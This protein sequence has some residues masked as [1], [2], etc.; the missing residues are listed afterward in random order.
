MQ[1]PSNLKIYQQ[2]AT[3]L[4]D[5]GFIKEI[6]FAGS[7]YQVLVEDPTLHKSCWV[8]LQLEGKGHIRDAFCS[9]E[10][11]NEWENSSPCVHLAAAYLSL[12]GKHSMPLHQRFARSLWNNLCRIY[13]DRLGDNPGRL[14]SIQPGYY[15]IQTGS[16][17][18]IFSVKAKSGATV[19]D[20]EN[21]VHRRPDET[22]ETSIKFSNLPEEEL[23]LWK[24]GKPSS[25]LR[26]ELSYWSDVAKWLMRLQ[27][28]EKKY[29]I[30]FKFSKKQLPN[31]IQIDFDEIE[32]GFYLSD[33]NL[34]A[35][36]PSLATVNSPLGVYQANNQGIAA[37]TYDKK[38]SSLNIESEIL[39]GTSLKSKRKKENTQAVFIEGWTYIPEQGFYSDEP[40]HLSQTPVLKGE[41]LANALTEYSQLI[42]RFLVDYEIHLNPIQVLHK[43]WFDR[44][45]NLHIQAYLLEEGDLSRNNSRIIGDWAF[46]DEDGF[47]RLEGKRFDEVDT[48]IPIQQVAD[49]VTLNRSW[50]NAQEGFET[51]VRSV[52]YQLSYSVNQN[53]RLSFSRTV[54]KMKE[55][56]KIQDFGSWVYLEGFGF[57]P[58]SVSSFG[59]LVRP[60]ISLSPE[61]IP[62]FI[63]MNHD[64]L[65]LIPE[66]F[67]PT[68]PVIK[69]S[70]KVELTDRQSVKITPEYELQPKYKNRDVRFFDEVVYV[71]GEGFSQLPP[72]LHLDE[73]YRHTVEL[74]GEDRDLFL[75]YEIFEFQK[76]ITSLD[77]RLIQPQEKL[78]VTNFV[79]TAKE[80]GRGW[81]QFAFFYKTEKGLISIQTMLTA[82][83]KKQTLL[84][85]DEGLIDL[86]DKR[87]DWL[88]QL[89]KNRVSADGKT[90]YLNALEF[91]RLNA[92]DPIDFLKTK[93]NSSESSQE[94]FDELLQLKTPEEPDIS[95]LLSHLRPYQ[96]IGVHWLWFLYHQQLSGLL[97]DD[98]GLGKTHQAMALLASI[99]NLYKTY[100]EG[101]SRHFLIVCPTSVIFHWQDKLQEFLPGIRIH[102]F[103][104]SNRSLDEFQEQYDVLLT[105]YGILRNE[106]EVL[107]KIPFEVAI[108]DEI[109]IAKNQSSRIY[110][111]LT[112][113]NSQMKLG[114]T[115]TPIENY[116]RE[117]KSLFDIVLPS[118]MPGE[119]DYRELFVRP[120]EREQNSHRKGLL[121]RLIKP[122][123]LRR[124]KEDVLKDLPEK[125]EEISHCELLPYQRQLY[126]EVLLQRRRHLLQE[127]ENESNPIPFL[128]IFALL[129]SLKQICDHPAVYL[130]KAHEYPQ[131]ESGKWELFLELL[132][133]AR[134][135]QQKVVVF[136]QY[137]GM[138]DIIE[139]YLAEHEIGFAAL[140]G[141]TQNRKE[142]IRKFN[143]DPEC[144]VFVGSLQAAGLGVDLTAGSVVIHYDRWWNAARENQ[145]TDRVHRI[146]QTRGVQVFKLVTRNTF[147][148][149]IDAMI[150][151]K[152]R[153]MEDVIG[154]D[155]SETLKKFSREDMID[156]L[157]LVEN[158]EERKI[159]S[160]PKNEGEF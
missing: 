114:L 106:L 140:R 19:K 100:A 46:L 89:K 28:E 128:H 70:L 155:D 156:L 136:S 141:A 30:S 88:R 3:Q 139:H 120:I 107:S 158:N 160:E 142:Q 32:V 87:F 132:N 62:L 91:M 65:A 16:E 110:A 24:E 64:E 67:A 76:K 122:F 25:Q 112:K 9:C 121:N 131:Y 56:I 34:A 42:S 52:E 58:K 83:R 102:T 17:T 144:E 157:S 36:I 97:C 73:K 71:E 78:L 84:F 126:S 6:E 18:V 48:I 47:Y 41:E 68:C 22:E 86:R 43:L 35:I 154:V 147:E 94:L 63:K 53:N 21:L 40:H 37:I 82:I 50:L 101:V 49:F 5:K 109:Q 12:Y 74:E 14:V 81:Y 31:W 149:K 98:M 127:L 135:S 115:G 10:E 124:K 57:Y 125:I 79:E 13:S 26:Y 133:E 153:L 27:E 20:L 1:L 44:N 118:Y 129:S 111:A 130:K 92:F 117:L 59:F 29:E 72:E 11:T 7:T 119:S 99:K 137:L 143:K 123:I 45:W 116:L 134:E 104:G 138:L 61:Q 93:S 96:E 39:T 159:G 113:I 105:S 151:R 55:G 150:E 51:H 103:Y 54:A 69:S 77:P 2:D 60:G 23:N 95:G 145:A 38:E 152:S 4:I 108:F 8:F 148:E 15:V 33:A 80:R 146:G 66:F 90:V 75:T 85:S